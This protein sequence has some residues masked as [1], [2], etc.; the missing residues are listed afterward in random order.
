MK[1]IDLKYPSFKSVGKWKAILST[2]LIYSSNPPKVIGDLGDYT[3]LVDQGND[4]MIFGNGLNV[5][6]YRG[7]LK[8][9][10]HPNFFP[11]G[12][13]EEVKHNGVVICK[14]TSIARR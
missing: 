14:V 3:L 11:I 13:S 9:E 10:N 12:K 8:G 7:H 5:W 4:F 6:F 1:E 2:N